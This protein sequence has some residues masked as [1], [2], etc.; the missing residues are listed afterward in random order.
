MPAFRILRTS[1]I[2]SLGIAFVIFGV[3]VGG[4]AP[5]AQVN[6]PELTIRFLAPT[7]DPGANLFP[8]VGVIGDGN[9]KYG[10]FGITNISQHASLRF[11]I[12]KIEWKEGGGWQTHSNPFF[13]GALGQNWNPGHGT[14]YCLPWPEGIADHQEWRMQIWVMHEPRPIFTVINSKLRRELFK[15]HSRYWITN[16][17][18]SLAERLAIETLQIQNQVP[19]Q[20]LSE[21]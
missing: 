8:K 1:F 18:A 20:A 4:S 11:G 3:V 7:N 10:L 17:V 14:L 21:K 2:L 19:I 12:E 15:P 6:A 9:G 5:Q 16:T 13:T